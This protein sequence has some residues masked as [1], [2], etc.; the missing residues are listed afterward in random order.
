[1]NNDRGKAEC[2]ENY[3]KRQEMYRHLQGLEQERRRVHTAEELEALERELRGYT[4]QLGALLL[5][6]TGHSAL[7]IESKESRLELEWSVMGRGEV[8][9]H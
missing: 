4:D 8:G 6:G 9:S 7:H 1:M 2:V 5:E 3:T